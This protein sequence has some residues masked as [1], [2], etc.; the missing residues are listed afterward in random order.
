M[1][2]KMKPPA[3]LL[4]G[5]KPKIQETEFTVIKVE[6][7]PGIAGEANNDGTIFVDENIPNG[8]VEEKEVVAHEAKH[9][10]DMEKGLLGYTDNHVECKGKK[11]ERKDCKIKYN[12]KWVEEGYK[13]FPWEKRAYKAGDAAVKKLK[14]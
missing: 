13:D 11:Y 4:F 7:D 14:K 9:M 6:L 12:G 8:S 1:G 5:K 3:E 2:Y 10:E